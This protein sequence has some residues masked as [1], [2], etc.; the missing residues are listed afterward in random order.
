MDNSAR[1]DEIAAT[2]VEGVWSDAAVI[3]I[4]GAHQAR[5]HAIERV[6][7]ALTSYEEARTPSW[8]GWQQRIAV[9]DPWE[10]RGGFHYCFFCGLRKR[11]RAHTRTCLW[12]NAKDATP[13]ANPVKETR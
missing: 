13:P 7:A 9:M 10:I 1:K 11:A 8:E 5:Q 12:Q 4:V 3:P 6:K 2:L